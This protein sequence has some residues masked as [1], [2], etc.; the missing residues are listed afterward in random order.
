MM[1]NKK[2]YIFI[3][4]VFFVALCGLLFSS[5]YKQAKEQSIKNL[6][7]EQMLAARQAARG[8]EDFFANWTRILITLTESDRI[9]TMDGTGK[10]ILESIQNNNADLIRAVTRVDARGR[11]I[12]TAPYDKQAIGRDIS[13]QKHIHEIMEKHRPV[14][15]D[16]FFAVQGY[17]TVALH[18]PV[19]QGNTYAGTIGLGINFQALAK[20]YMEGIQIGKTGYAWVISRDGTELFCP[21]PGHTGKTV[22]ENCKNFPSI[23]AMAE[24]MMRGREGTTV[25]YYDK[26]RNNTVDT[27]KKHAAY[28][29]ISLGNTFW[30]IVVAS[31][32]DE[33]LSSLVGFRNR[34]ILIVAI[35]LLGGIFFSYYG[36]KAWLIVEE[37]EKRKRAEEAVRESEQ[38]FRELAE[39]LPE[40]IYESDLHG[41]LH[42]VN[43]RGFDFLGYTTEE[44]T[45]GL[46]IL[47][48]VAPADRDRARD[49]VNKILSGENI[50]ANEYILQKKDGSTLSVIIHSSVIV[51]NGKPAGLRGFI[52]DIT[53]RKEAEEA[54]RL[55]TALLEAQVNTSI[56]GILVIDHNQKRLLINRR[57]V[58]LWDVPQHIL[59]DDDDTALLHYVVGLVKYPDAFLGKVMYL[60]EHPSETSWDE[61]E[62]KDGMVLDRYSAPV[63]GTDGHNYGRIWTFRD[64][65]ERKRAENALANSEETLRTLV[66]ATRETLFLIDTNGTVLVANE[67]VASRL[68]TTVQAMTGSSIYTFFPPDIAKSRK[69][70]YDTVVR[71]GKPVR[72]ED[73]RAGRFFESFVYPVFNGN[74]EV[75]RV[76]VY[77]EEITAR[78]KVEREREDLILEL[79]EAL[80]KVKVLSGLLPICSSCKKIRNDKGTWES[81]EV[82]IRDRSDAEFSHGICPECA[83]RLYP[84]HYKNR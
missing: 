59:D 38:R 49:N 6:N 18:V 22:F 37:E 39:L 32:E 8:I 66:D 36:M 52:I 45:N 50:G 42:Y 21:V 69:E 20:R 33:V 19:F 30:S 58:E 67:T 35:L 83:K 84:E 76:A 16:V 14:V 31:S 61:I 24:D 64:I 80:S 9:R 34:L 68:C 71:T 25:Y 28:M 1:G 5:F 40:A 43:K 81:M 10:N 47:D 63:L 53:A 15:S 17:S 60:Y 7:A 26:I 27:V 62:F 3:V 57:I 78:K 55:K 72:F 79:Q 11:I 70:H 74:G 44:Y 46:N 73:E 48:T 41:N 51:K 4:F 13:S 82:Y 12:Y 65:T 54:L 56:D 77:A 23:L 75:S 2:T 29:P